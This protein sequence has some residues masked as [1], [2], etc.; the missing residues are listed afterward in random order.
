MISERTFNELMKKNRDRDSALSFLLKDLTQIL[1]RGLVRD[2]KIKEIMKILKKL[3]KKWFFI[4]FLCDYTFHSAI[5]F[6]LYPFL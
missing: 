5:F 4:P 2:D 1:E 6:Y 3:S